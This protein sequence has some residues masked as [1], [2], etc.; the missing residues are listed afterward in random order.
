LVLFEA[1]DKELTWPA[2]ML[3]PSDTPEWMQYT[4]MDALVAEE[5]QGKSVKGR[6]H[7]GCPEI[8]H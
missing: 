7:Y 1:L 4:T 5:M 8:D 3:A 6:C 2:P